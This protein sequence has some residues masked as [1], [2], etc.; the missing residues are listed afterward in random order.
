MNRKK[1]IS[2]EPS[3]KSFDSISLDWQKYLQ[4]KD[5]EHTTSPRFLSI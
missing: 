5:K 1:V 4:V 2:N 3:W